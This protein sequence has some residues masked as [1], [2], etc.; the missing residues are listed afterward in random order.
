MLYQDGGALSG[1]LLSRDLDDHSRTPV[2]TYWHFDLY[3]VLLL[4][5]ISLVIILLLPLLIISP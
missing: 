3:S 4:E 2:T 5:L 1:I